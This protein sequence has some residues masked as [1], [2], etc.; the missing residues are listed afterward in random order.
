[1]DISK[2]S[3]F[4]RFVYLLLDKD[5]AR[6]S[7]LF[8]GVKSGQGFDL[9]DLMEAVN[10][11]YGFA[12]GK[13]THSDRLQTIKALYEQHGELVDPHTAD[14]IKVAKELQREGEVIVCAET[15]LPFKFADTIVE[16]I[17]HIEITRPAHTEGLEDLPQHVVVLDNKAELVAEQI[18]QHVTPN[19]A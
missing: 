8:E 3:N 13:S 1:M 14:G 4:E 7:E 15:A 17:G 12:A 11:R 9:S 2:A 19:L 16:A 18:R 5:S 6:V 10:T